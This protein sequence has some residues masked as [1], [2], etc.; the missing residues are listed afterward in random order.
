MQDVAVA[1]T[2]VPPRPEKKRKGKQTG[3]V[4]PLRMMKILIKVS[5]YLKRI[6]TF[7]DQESVPASKA[8]FNEERP[9]EKIPEIT[10]LNDFT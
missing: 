3:R 6:Y 7:L 5:I 10:D 2:G 9:D 1:L 8:N 4:L